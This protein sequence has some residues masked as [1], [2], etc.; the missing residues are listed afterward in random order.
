MPTE[1]DQIPILI[2]SKSAKV[3][4]VTFFFAS[5]DSR[6]LEKEPMIWKFQPY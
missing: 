3:E 4:E 5:V 6:I 2:H 1:S